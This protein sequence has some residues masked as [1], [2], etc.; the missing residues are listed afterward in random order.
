M[1]KDKCELISFESQGTDAEFAEFNECLIT[2]R[3]EI[4]QF[5]ESMIAMP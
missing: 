1:A 5:F 4:R 3:K 2:E